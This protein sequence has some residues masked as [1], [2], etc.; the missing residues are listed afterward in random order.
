MPRY[1]ADQTSPELGRLATSNAL[2]LLPVGTVEE[3]GPH[4]PVGTDALI[5]ERVAAAAADAL[6]GEIPTLVMPP[7]WTGYSAKGMTR[8]PGTIRLRT[9]TVADIVVQVCASLVD[10]GF[11]KILIV[12]GHGHH[13][14]LLEMAVREVADATGTYVAC[15][16]PAAMAAE[17]FQQIRRS[18]PGGAI[19]GGE[20]ETSLMLHF[21]APVQM[22]EATDVDTVQYHSAFIA[23]DNFAG[24]SK[25]FWSTWALHQSQTGL[26]GDP[27]VATA[28]TGRR[29]MEA[30]V[31][32]LAQ[33][34]REFHA[35]PR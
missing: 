9:R 20:Y 18:A 7:I 10:M 8:W 24:K 22:D 11:R 35:H 6:E 30:I 13:T 34:A 27:T 16:N 17:L 25:A 23:G 19:H 21:G 29:L 32:N 4:L 33:F 15:V 31:T 2:V 3:H 5:V 14:G 1:F 28:E 12:H 26:L